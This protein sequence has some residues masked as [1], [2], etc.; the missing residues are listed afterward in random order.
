MNKISVIVPVYNGEKD[1][2]RCLFSLLNQTLPVDIIV[3]DDGSSDKTN[4]I[5]NKIAN[6]HAGLIHYYYKENGGISTTRNCGVEHV[7]TEYF[8]FLDSD[9]YVEPE[10]YATMLT[11]IEKN[12]SDICICNFL[13]VYEKSNK[14][15]K[16][17]GYK[18]KHDLLSRMF[19]TLWNKLYRTNWFNETG[20]KFPNGLRYE[21]ASVLYRLVLHMNK[22]CYVDQAFV[23]YVQRPGSITHTFNININDMIEVFKGIKQYYIDSGYYAEYK[24]EIEYLFIRFFLGN[25]YLR[26]CRINDVQLRKETLEKGWNFL[27]INYPDFKNNRY[28]KNSGFKNRYFS[29]MNKFLYYKNVYIFRMLYALRI[30]K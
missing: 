26:A 21:D 15:A 29:I 12:N 22:V 8:G 2:E 16:D 30:M 3:V 6:E 18:D 4:E 20:I 5:V 23:N 9:D 24:D 14:L 17:I 27:Q 25:S 7:E 11:E 28:L 10:M 1:I 19:A 13:W